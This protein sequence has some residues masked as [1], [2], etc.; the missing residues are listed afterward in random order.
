MSRLGGGVNNRGAKRKMR[1]IE[2]AEKERRKKENEEK[3]RRIYTVIKY[4]T[5]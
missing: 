4:L 1:E 3:K 2:K 5:V